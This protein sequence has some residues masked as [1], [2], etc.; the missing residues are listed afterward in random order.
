[1]KFK[2]PTLTGKVRLKIPAGTQTNTKFRLRGK[3]IRNVHGQGTCKGDQ[4]V[5][6]K[7]I[8]PTKLT[9]KTKTITP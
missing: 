5:D 3:G 1:M 2:Y 8:T 4:H 7:I 9:E 6:V